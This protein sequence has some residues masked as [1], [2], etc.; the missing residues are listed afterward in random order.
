MNSIRY[1]LGFIAISV[2][3]CGGCS[4][5]KHH[6]ADREAPVTTPTAESSGQ[7]DDTAG[8]RD[9]TH[10]YAAAINTNNTDQIMAMC[11]E[12]VVFMP[13]NQPALMGQVAVRKWLADYLAAY[14]VRED[15]A[16]VEFTVIGDWA[17]ERCASTETDT[18]RA[19]GAA[20]HDTLKGIVTYHREAD[21]HWRVA[22]DIW[23]SD[24]PAASAAARSPVR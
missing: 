7:T 1:T 12:D 16:T 8:A 5:H 22:R 4:H 21:G 10:A 13:P 18:P 3:M 17:I 14:S 2:L 24:L 23:N 11:T 20:I 6:A 15:F 19:G 9:A